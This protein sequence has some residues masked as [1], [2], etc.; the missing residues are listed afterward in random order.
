MTVHDLVNEYVFKLEIETV[1]TLLYL[2]NFNFIYNVI[3]FYK[4]NFDIFW[5]VML[6]HCH[7]YYLNK[8]SGKCS[9]ESIYYVIIKFITVF[10][11]SIFCYFRAFREGDPSCYLQLFRK[12]PACILLHPACHQETMA[13]LKY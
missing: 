11:Y 6:G 13:Q 10:E 7:W 3:L 5:I 1:G 12:I 8:I 9:V 4:L 2:Y